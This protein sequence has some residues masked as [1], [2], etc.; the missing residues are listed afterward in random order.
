MSSLNAVRIRGNL[1]RVSRASAV[2]TVMSEPTASAVQNSAIA[3]STLRGIRRCVSGHAARTCRPDAGHCARERR[4]TATGRVRERSGV[5]CDSDSCGSAAARDRT[6][7]GQS[8]DRPAKLRVRRSPSAASRA[9][10]RRVA[11][12]RFLVAY[13]VAVQPYRAA[14]T[15]RL[16]VPRT[17]SKPSSV[18]FVVKRDENKN[19]E[20]IHSTETHSTTL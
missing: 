10:G 20:Y 15:S 16:H 6:V 13:G 7:T 2:A 1:S 18:R 17:Y 3:I 19:T 12:C 4:S 9:R 8:A 14:S 11:V 5:R